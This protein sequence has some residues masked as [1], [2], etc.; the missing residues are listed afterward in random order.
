MLEMKTKRDQAQRNGIA[1][2]LVLSIAVIYIL[3]GLLLLYVPQVQIIT[4]CY[5]LCAIL[6]VAGIVLIVR[7]FMTNAYT[8]MNEYGFSVG[9]FTVILGMCALVRVREVA[10]SFLICM[11]IAMLL[12]SVIKLQNALD[13][14]NLGVHTWIAMLVLSLA[15]LICSIIIIIHPFKQQATLEAF[16][17]RVLILDGCISLI[18]NLYLYL[19]LRRNQ[20]KM[21]MS[22][23]EKEESSNDETEKSET[24]EDIVSDDSLKEE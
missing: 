21:P 1:S 7:Y 22:S 24:K 16:T 9:V 18:G 10:N 13:L 5:L 14:K 8:N 15:F 12:T 19:M 3:L 20:K 6:V 23:E 17:F 4:I 11:G 2:Q